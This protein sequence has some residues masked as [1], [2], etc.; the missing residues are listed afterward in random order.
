M[1]K[2][3]VEVCAKI[4]ST[5][6]E[7]TDAENKKF[8]VF[9]VQLPIKGRDESSKMLDISVSADGDSNDL[10]TYSEGRRVHVAGSMT[11]YKKE[12]KVYF[13]LRS[14]DKPKIV[15]FTDSDKIEGNMSFLGKTSKKEIEEHEDKNKNP[16]KSFSAFS[17]NKNGDNYEYIW[18]R[19]LYFRP[20]EDNILMP[21]TYIKVNGVLQLGVFKDEI[22]IDCRVAEI[23]PWEQ[24][25]Q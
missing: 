12:G 23:E 25:K 15:N 20:K 18:V 6:V 10:N 19:F 2:C 5:A 22:S 1:I 13:S 3:D 21:S 7:K 4:T 16:Y 8:I 9:G 17:S 14:K 11:I 24:T